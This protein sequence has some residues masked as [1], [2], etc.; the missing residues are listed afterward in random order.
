[1]F[2][3]PFK[4]EADEEDDLPSTGSAPTVEASDQGL[5]H[6]YASLK[7]MGRGWRGKKRDKI[8]QLNRPGTRSSMI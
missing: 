7:A 1:M 3:I 4:K 2:R 8:A 6:D 5:E